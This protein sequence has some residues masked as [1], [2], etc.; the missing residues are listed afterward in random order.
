MS[1]GYDIGIRLGLSSAI[2][3]VIAAPPMVPH[4]VTAGSGWTGMTS[5]PTVT[6]A[7][8]GFTTPPTQSDTI[9]G[10]GYTER[11][12]AN[13][14]H[15]YYDYVENDSYYIMF[16]GG[17]DHDRTGTIT[18]TFYLENDTPVTFTNADYK[19]DPVR[20]IFGLPIAPKRKAGTSGVARWYM[21]A[22]PANGKERILTGEV[23]F[24]FFGDATGYY[25][26]DA[27]AIYVSGDYISGTSHVAG[28]NDATVGTSGS[29]NYRIQRA[30]QFASGSKEG[31]NVYIRG[32]VKDDTNGASRPTTTLPCRIMPWLGYTKADTLWGKTSRLT[33]GASSN[34]GINVTI[35]KYEVNGIRIDTDSIV[36]FQ[37]NSSTRL[38]H[39][40][41][42]YMSDLGL[43]PGILG[44]PQGFLQVVNTASGVSNQQWVTSQNGEYNE[45]IDCDGDIICTGGFHKFV[46]C[47]INYTWD[48]MYHGNAATGIRN[49]AV[50]SSKFYGSDYAYARFHESTELTVGSVS[51]DGNNWTQITFS[52]ATTSLRQSLF[53]TRVRIL[54][55]A[56]AGTEKGRRTSDYGS[57][58]GTYP[59]SGSAGDCALLTAATRGFPTANVLYVKGDNL[60][61]MGLAIGDKLR[62]YNFAH[63]DAMQLVGRQSGDP[64]FENILYHNATIIGFDL[65]TA[66]TQNGPWTVAGTVG[67]ASGTNL[68]FTTSQTMKEGDCIHFTA[69]HEFG[70]IVSGSGTSYVIDRSVTNG[71]GLAWTWSGSTKDVL[72]ENSVFHCITNDE[73]F[74]AN[75]QTGT[76][77][78]NIFYSTYIGEGVTNLGG[79]FGM[80]H[81]SGGYGTRYFKLKDSVVQGFLGDAGGFPAFNGY[82]EF[83]NNHA[84]RGTTR[85]TNCTVGDTLTSSRGS[86]T[87]TYQ[88]TA[89]GMSTVTSPAVPYDRNGNTRSTG[90]R[91]GAAV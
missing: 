84:F 46:N 91:V 69:T 14:T 40:G 2:N 26:R 23:W 68:T 74:I 4:T 36:Q 47:D 66:L 76:I 89:S 13:S 24:N 63:K 88:P 90:S 19:W 82:L 44:Y 48:V 29:P 54:T 55:G 15:V 32:W 20:K 85:G 1:F 27:N 35:N 56:L 21:K 87:S 77:N 67:V 86:K 39:R 58:G 38:V 65:Q 41:V 62:V 17:G 73:D 8:T 75:W 6:G 83:D 16:R 70:F 33:P 61:A 50:F 59:S 10:T 71:S 9:N 18:W 30:L 81:Q 34:G 11:V 78:V 22:T 51:Y 7:G 80:R 49:L 12:I 42:T 25:N 64:Y 53:E 57:S 43:T 28:T 5:H 3:A 52:E 60:G 37:G 72:I 45:M 79:F 31:C